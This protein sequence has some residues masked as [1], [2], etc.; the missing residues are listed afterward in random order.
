MVVWTLEH[1]EYLS[2]K[3]GT[4]PFASIAEKLGRTEKAV[5]N[6][7]YTN[8]IKMY[9]QFYTA[10]LLADELGVCHR[11]IMK[12]H[13]E[14]LL[15]GKRAWW[16]HGYKQPCMIFTENGI[17]NFLRENYNKFGTR[18]I[19]KKGGR[20]VPNPYFNSIIEREYGRD[21]LE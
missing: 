10:R 2:D 17:V 6:K 9:D 1:I 13:K 12:W 8:G 14:G 20:Y 3:V 16:R 5:R 11:S 21:I 19:P 18:Y 7:A 15:L 4:M